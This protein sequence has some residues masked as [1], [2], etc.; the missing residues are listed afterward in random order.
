MRIINSTSVTLTQQTPHQLTFQGQRHTQFQITILDDDLVRVQH[1]PAGKPRL[2]RTWTITA[3]AA[4]VPLSGRHRDDLSGFAQPGFKLHTENEQ[5]NIQ[6]KQLKIT[7]NLSDF[8]LRWFTADDQ[9]FAADLKKR[10]YPYD[11][12][13]TS[14]FHYMER[15]PEEHYYGFGERAGK[16]DKHGM[17]MR[18][19]NVDALGYNAES[20]DPLY[21]H[22]PFYITYNPALNIAYGLFYDN[23]ATT[24]F[25]MGKE[26]DAFWGFYRY[27]QAD[28]GDLDYY[29]IYGP[30]IPE[31]IEKYT[32]LTGKPVLPPRWSLG[33]LGSTMHY[34]EAPDAQEQLKQFVELCDRHNIPCDMFQL[35]SGYTTD[36]RGVRYVFTWNKDKVPDP[37]QMT[38]HFHTAGIKLSANVKPYLLKSHPRY[39]E[40]ADQTGFIR[41]AEDNTPVTSTFWSG[42]AFESGDGGYVDFTSEAGYYW[43]QAR[44]KEA[45]FAYGIDVIWNDN[46]EFEVWDDAARCAGFGSVIPVGQA[47]PLQ[48]LLMA[49]ASYEATRDHYSDRR[50][51]V[52]TRAG[53]AGIQRYAQTWS[54][55][56]ETSWH[57]LR[58]NIPMGL[59]LGL[60]GM[61]NT[62]HDVGGFYGPAPDAELFVRWVQNGVFHPRFTIH[63][64]NTDGT[65]NEPWMHPDVI[66]LVREAINFRYRLLPYLYTL[67]YQASQTGQPII[68]PMV[69]HFPHDARCRSESFDFMLGP[70]LL[71]ASV[72]E[73][74]GRTRLVYLPQGTHWYN[75]YT[76]EYFTGGQEIELD[77]PLTQIPLLA[78]EGAV[79]PMGKLMRYIGQQPDNLRQVYSFPHRAN[80]HSTF[81]LVENDGI[82]LA[83]QTG[84]VTYVTLE[85]HSTPEQIT[86]VVQAQGRYALPYTE[87][88]FILPAGETRTVQAQA[89][90]QWVDEDGRQHIVVPIKLSL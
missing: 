73:A 32:F 78:R 49:R 44:L 25:D 63:S 12:A 11:Q 39:K 69:Y 89:A 68:R 13:G 19:M 46:N 60:S 53:C 41:Q 47:R 6:T 48:T 51:F 76:G 59:G 8:N 55:D 40:L 79:V 62:G 23:A 90:Q 30:S 67:F 4:D 81:T 17:R 87:I 56:N 5:L 70:N 75:F 9:L 21:K 77:A 2:D 34:T 28:D 37:H 1:F 58:Y 18:M 61:P 38:S 43:W 85:M 16:L 36:Q 74:G 52:L 57:T 14:I 24:I 80:G 35:S 42:G 71:I 64:W 86:L 65:V 20:S 72:L 7:I 83:Y 88:E 31:V 15:R 29:L 3:G 54:G 82:S 84:E 33:Y 27:Y 26:I 50:P 22:M 45:L 66:P 10:G